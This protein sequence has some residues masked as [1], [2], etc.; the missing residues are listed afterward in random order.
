MVF[1]LCLF[2][3]LPLL[4]CSLC[5]HHAVSSLHR[6]LFPLIPHP[7]LFPTKLRAALICFS[8]PLFAFH[9]PSLYHV[10]PPHLILQFLPSPIL[11]LYL[12]I[13]YCFFCWP[14]SWEIVYPFSPCLL[15]YHLLTHTLFHSPNFS[16]ITPWFLPCPHPAWIFFSS[17]AV[18]LTSCI[19]LPCAF[20][21]LLFLSVPVH[22]W[23]LPS[24][25]HIHL[26]LLPFKPL[27][28]GKTMSLKQGKL[29]HSLS[30]FPI[31]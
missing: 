9:S 15:L 12:F 13:S 7:L 29:S 26:L 5:I 22:R 4:R 20:I 16:W 23:N 1:L 3:K 10:F 24:S 21:S 31:L 18:F 30:T 25:A 28:S 6:H 11:T 27:K 19:S 17:F 8:S 14:S 2:S